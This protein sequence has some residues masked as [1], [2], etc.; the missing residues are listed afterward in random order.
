VGWRGLMAVK[1]IQLPLGSNPARS[2][3]ASDT[4]IINGFVEAVKDSAKTSAPIYGASGLELW[5]SINGGLCRG[6]IEADGLLYVVSG[7]SLL[8]VTT[9]GVVTVLGI[10]PGTSPVIMARNAN[11]DT[12]I[13]IVA[14]GK[15]YIATATTCTLLNVPDILVD[16]VSVSWLDGFFIFALADGRFFISNLNG[17]E[18]DALDFA[19]AEGDPD[20]LVRGYVF[21]RELYL[22]GPKTIEVWA[23]TG[24]DFPFARLSGAVVTVGLGAKHSVQQ[25]GSSLYFVDDKGLVRKMIGGYQSQRVS[26][27]EVERLIEGLGD[28][29]SLE[30]LSYTSKGHEYYAI[31]SSEWTWVYDQ[32]T[33]EWAE[34]K[35]GVTKRWQANNAIYFGGRF[36]VGSKTSPNLYRIT[37]DAF[38]EDGEPLIFTVRFPVVDTFPGGATVSALELDFETGVGTEEGFVAQ[39]I[40]FDMLSLL[41]D[42]DKITMDQTI[43][44]RGDLPN[45]PGKFPNR[46]PLVMLRWSDNGGKSWSTGATAELGRQGESRRVRFTR[47]GSFG[48]QGR[49]FEASI[50]A[51]IFRAFLA[52]YIVAEPKVA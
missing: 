36:V 35:T 27:Y 7:S 41:W 19:S 17:I 49:I 9:V 52:A 38:D 6:M 42:S 34:R 25:V 24:A 5:T 50:S 32:S 20:G 12:Q 26:N 10:I 1:R 8:K 37:D 47:L 31:S 51:S 28:Y 39:A 15:V 13:A 40:T 43:D 46:N 21:G 2:R 14:G 23:N 18:I 44:H 4:R 11:A 45:V 22:F 3:L 48:R 30:S 16:V 33:G 29:S